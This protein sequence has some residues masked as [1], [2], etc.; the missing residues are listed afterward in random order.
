MWLAVLP[1]WVTMAST[2]LI[3]VTSPGKGSGETST[4][5]SGTCERSAV[6]F[7]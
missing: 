4:A 1:T 3:T 7:R 2:L 6:D 5:P